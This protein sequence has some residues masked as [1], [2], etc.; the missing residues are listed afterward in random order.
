MTCSVVLRRSGDLAVLASLNDQGHDAHFLGGQAV[1]D[2]RAHH[3][4]LGRLRQHELRRQPGFA[5]GHAA[6]A[7][8]QRR[9]G[10]VA[11]HHAAEA[12]LQV[13]CWRF[14]CFPR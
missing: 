5:G 10:D 6:H 7:L 4:L 13:G 9:A 1:A 3:I 12:L 11:K 2:A 14:R 8:H